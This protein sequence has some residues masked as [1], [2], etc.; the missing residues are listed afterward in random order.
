[1]TSMITKCK[2]FGC[3]ICGAVKGLPG[4]KGGDWSQCFQCPN[5]HIFTYYWGFHYSEAAGGS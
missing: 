4:P 2:G 3:P 5:G 1:M